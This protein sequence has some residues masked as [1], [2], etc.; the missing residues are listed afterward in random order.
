MNLYLECKMGAAGDMLTAA[1]L[2]LLDDKDAFL[3]KMR[4]LNLPGVEIS[5][6][7]AEKCGI[8]GTH[9]SVRVGG[10]EER[11]HDVHAH[12][13]DH[14]YGENPHRH[15]HDHHHGGETSPNHTHITYPDIRATIAALPMP[16]KVREDALAVYAILAAAE[17]EAHGKPME[18]IHFHEVGTLD[19]V[20]DIVGCC[21]LMDMLGITHVEASPVHVGS[22]SVRCSHGI[23]P[24]PTPATANILRGVPIY[25][26]EI[27]GELCTPTGAALLRHF[28]ARFGPMPPMTVLKVGYGMG[29][30]DFPAANC[31]RAFLYSGGD[32]GGDEIT[33]I[34]C[35][36]DDMTPE[37]VSAA[38]DALLRGGALDVFMTPVIMKKSRPAVMLTLLCR[39][40]DE[41]AMTRLL[42]T[43]TSTLGIRLGRRSR[44]TLTR[45]TVTADTPY[46]KIRV[47]TARGFGARR[48]KPEYDDVLAAAEK[49]GVPFSHVFR[50]AEDAWPKMP[51]Q[52]GDD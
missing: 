14:D 43:H 10:A 30:K 31:V 22:G 28:S 23:M 36:L 13:H 38:M 15:H 46:G 6:E 44:R 51:E 3:G 16:E 48:G 1:L 24:V 27:Q 42:F 26:G 37:A 52:E 41:G 11:S 12:H 9:F 5:H 40:E 25:G 21:L 4:A 8:A 7:P 39:P 20:A 18:H 2:E 34:A 50:A 17:A 32:E 45:E 33:E 29:R 49:R 35:N 47:K 19:A